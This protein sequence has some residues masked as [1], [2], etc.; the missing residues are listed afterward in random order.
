MSKTTAPKNFVLTDEHRAQLKP[1]GDK[2]VKNSLSCEPMNS[3]DDDVMRSAI[4]G[5][6]SCAGFAA[7]KV[8]RILFVPSPFA[9][10]FVAGACGAVLDN[11]GSF[12]ATKAMRVKAADSPA[13]A[14][15]LE[16]IESV[17]RDDDEPMVS[18]AGDEAERRFH[19]ARSDEA[20]HWW[21]DGSWAQAV[22]DLV[23]KEGLACADKASAMREGGNLWSGWVAYVTFFRYVVGLD[24]DYSKWDHYEKAAVHGGVRYMEERFCTVSDRP[25]GNI[26]LNDE[27]QLH[28]EDGA[29]IRW[30]DGTALYLIEGQY[31]PAWT[32]EHP[33]RVVADDISKEENEEVRRIM[34]NRYGVG[35]FL[36]D[37]GGKLLDT[38][39]ETYR[40]GSA[41]RALLEDKWGKKWLYGTDGGTGRVYYMSVPDRA[42]TC[43][44]AHELRCGFDETKILAKS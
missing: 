32:V 23:G 43:R 6:Y 36:L 3:K 31:M 20:R 15:V 28:R 34:M 17:L 27:Q 1:W 25:T 16:A 12:K 29:A 30:R 33:E 5:I 7:P 14:I 39:V 10:C 38:D 35:R 44:E 21:A 26:W 18:Y 37:T 13:H 9:A 22:R 41:P 42:T 11:P 24:L 4:Q 8:S 19:G 40:K 2:W